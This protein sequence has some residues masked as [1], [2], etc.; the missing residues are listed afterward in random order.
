MISFTLN[1]AANVN[2]TSYKGFFHADYQEIVSAF[3]PPNS[4]GDG[5]KVSCEWVIEFEDGLVATI[6]DWKIGK[7][8]SEDGFGGYGLEPEE[9]RDWNIG[10]HTGQVVERVK[11]ILAHHR[12]LSGGNKFTEQ[13]KAHSRAW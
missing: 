10:G 2:G 12:A 7:Y 6:Y 1:E 3:G 8:W 9:I 5:Y 13:V 4:E 11:N